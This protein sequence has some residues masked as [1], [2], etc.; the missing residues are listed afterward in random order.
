MPHA[1]L[2]TYRVPHTSEWFVCLPQRQ[3]QRLCLWPQAT[4]ELI[5]PFAAVFFSLFSFFLASFFWLLFLGAAWLWDAATDCRWLSHE[6]VA[7]LRQVTVKAALTM[8][9][10]G[11]V[12]CS[13]ASNEPPNHRATELLHRSLARVIVMLKQ[14]QF[15]GNFFLFLFYS[16]PIFN[17]RLV[18]SCASLKYENFISFY[19]LQC[20]VNFL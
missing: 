6:S 2:T 17:C 10:G 20:Q 14:N 1:P 9:F 4:L 12:P 15:S 11:R 18:W 5:E 13:Q 3:R 8:N 7:A 19:Q 16:P